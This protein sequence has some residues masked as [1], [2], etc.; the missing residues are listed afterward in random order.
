MEFA[1][2]FDFEIA[3]FG[4]SGVNYTAQAKNNPLITP[5]FFV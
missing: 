3:D 1:K 2:I 4:L 5:L